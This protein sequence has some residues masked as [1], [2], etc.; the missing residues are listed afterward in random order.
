MLI[1]AVAADTATKKFH[2][3]IEPYKEARE[4]YIRLTDTMAKEDLD[5]W[6]AEELE[7]KAHGG[8]LLEKLYALQ[9]QKSQLESL[10][11]LCQK[12]CDRSTVPQLFNTDQPMVVWFL[13][14]FELEKLQ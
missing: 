9:I 8:T 1:Y 4:L 3:G 10:P 7:A 5:L 2:A 11:E 13:N 12:L 14:A 6:N